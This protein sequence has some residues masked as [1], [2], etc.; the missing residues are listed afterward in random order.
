[1]SSLPRGR[2]GRALAATGAALALAATGCLAAPLTA[3]AATTRWTVTSPDGGVTADVDLAGGRLTLTAKHG[4]ATVLTVAGLGISTSVADLSVGLS[5]EDAT[6]SHVHETYTMVTGKSHAR[7]VDQNELRLTVGAPTTQYTVLVRASHDGVAYSYELPGTGNFAG[8]YTVGNETA[9]YVLP[10]ANAKAW[11]QPY[12]TNYENDHQVSTVGGSVTGNIG[13]PALFQTSSSSSSD[14]VFLTESGVTGTYAATH[15][16]HAAGSTTYGTELGNPQSGTRVDPVSAAGAL[17]TP[18]RLAIFG[19]LGTV[20]DSTMVDDLAHPDRLAGSDTSWIRPGTS[21]WSWNMNRGSGPQG[22]L[23]LQKTFVD[24]AAKEGWPYT[25]ID[26]G[27]DPAWVPE[28]VRYANARGVDVIAWFNSNQMQTARQRQDWFTKLTAW[29]VKGIKVDFMDSDSQKTF[30]WYDAILQE[31]ADAHL[32]INFH[33]ATLPKGM[34]RTWPQIMSYEGVRGEENG[35]SAQRNTILPFTRNVVGSM[36]YTPVVFTDNN[37][38]SQAHEIALPVL[39]ESG[40]T[41]YADNPGA[42]TSRPVAERFLQ[43]IDG[44]WDD[45]RYVAGT[46]GTSAVIAR[47]SGERWFVGGIT[48]GS[49]GTQ[50]VPLSFL[51]AGSWLVHLITDDGSSLGETVSQRT[52]ADTLQIPTVTNG[53]FAVLACPAAP[54]RTSCYQDV[55]SVPTSTVTATASASA[56]ATGDV[57][58]LSATFHLDGGAPVS[59]LDLAPD[60]PVTWQLIDGAPVTRQSVAGGEQVSGTW[61]LRVGSGGVRGDLA[62]T[63][64]ARFTTAAGQQI[65]S[66]GAAAVTVA[67][68]GLH[69]DVSLS[70]LTPSSSTIGWGSLH[71]D[72]DFFGDPINMLG[73]DG[74]DTTYPRAIEVN[75]VSTLAYDVDGQCQSFSGIVGLEQSDADHPEQ[76]NGSITFQVRDQDGTVLA[77]SSATIGWDSPAVPF[78]VSLDGVTRLVLYAGDGGDGNNSD[79]VVF[80]NAVLRCQAAGGDT[81]KP[82]VGIMTASPRAAVG[83][84]LAAPVTA[85]VQAWDD[86]DHL[87]VEYSEDGGASWKAYSAPVS[88]PEGNRTVQARATDG[89]GNVSDVATRTLQVD[90]TAP[91][92]TAVVSQS[93]RTVTVSA[94]DAGSGVA[95]IEYRVGDGAWSAYTGPVVVGDATTVV[96]YRATDRLGHV[97]ATGSATVPAKAVTPGTVATATTVSVPSRYAFGAGAA[98]TVKVTAADGRAVPGAV[99]VRDGARVV[100]TGTV[101]SGSA[102]LTLP[103]DLA[104][105][106]HTLNV[107]YAGSGPLLSSTAQARLTVTKAASALRLKIKPK[108]VTTRKRAK[109]KVMVTTSTG[110]RAVGKAKVVVKKGR[111]KA[112]KKTVKVRNGKAAVRLPRLKKGVW[113]VTASYKGSAT[114]TAAKART[115]AKVKR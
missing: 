110:T 76:H 37:E 95:S 91:T 62:L 1:V 53:G 80:A 39:Y 2:T 43:Q 84:W 65:R 71:V 115:K 12:A 57:V 15:L 82:T 101:V 22:N 17:A 41:H 20:V 81:T 34:Q 102:R 14:Y 10:D 40:W 78:D 48:N 26:E 54:G 74:Q 64:S 96:A 36:D 60:V 100:G 44:T 68:T 58:T 97:S 69:G 111:T 27:W 3:T 89:S 50:S 33:G 103:K 35:R 88:V 98:L 107:A 32:M 77:Q 23:A 66:A 75:S 61:K 6:T 52:S 30:Q 19:G 72:S 42:Y 113:K 21:A 47:R 70:D 4:A 8:A 25:V 105:G 13:F 59:D 73:P 7:T 109:V 112:L 86:D 5:V 46:P 49:Q 55:P 79:H 83:G 45:T 56:V 94:S 92:A 18:W 85:T 90:G 31:T 16:T 9:S 108:K 29:G 11:L 24:L 28:L 99:T 38:T 87:T 51:G 63:A 106:P 67:P 104:V 114:T 93:A